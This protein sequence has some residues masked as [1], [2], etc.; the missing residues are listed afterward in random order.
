MCSKGGGTPPVPSAASTTFNSTTQPA[1]SVSPMYTDFLNRAKDL[2]NTPFNSAQ[3]GTVA[4]MNAQQTAAGN[5]MF[6]Q[7]MAMGEWGKNLGNFDA[8]RVRAI[9]SPYIQDVV[10]ATQ[11]WFNNQNAIQGN[12]LLSQAIKSGNAFGGDR[13]GIA[14]AQLSGQQQLA[15]AP[16]I[17]GLYQSGYTQALDEY[18][19]LKQFEVTGR[20]MGLQGAGAAMGWGGLQQQQAQKE[21]D[22]AQQ[23]AMM[24]SAYP[25]Q[26]LN[27]YGSI[28]GGIGPLLGQSAFGSNN[29]PEQSGLGSAL[30]VGSAAVGL[31]TA[32]AGGGGEG[33]KRGG[34]VKQRARGGLVPVLVRHNGG[35]I[36]G[37]AYGGSTD[38]DDEGSYG[39]DRSEGEARESKQRD[40]VDTPA[41]AT[42]PQDT[43]GARKVGVPN[44]YGQLR[45]PRGQAP[46]LP[47]IP[48]TGTTQPQQ[49]S[50]W[51]QG[52]NLATKAIPLATSLF[53]LSD[54]KTKTDVQ[55][56]GKTDDGEPL[57]G[58]RYKGDPK[59]YPKVVGPMA[60]PHRDDG[61]GIGGDLDGEIL[62]DADPDPVEAGQ[63]YAR[64]YSGR[65]TWFNP[66]NER[67]GY[68]YRDDSGQ[69]WTDYGAQRLR[70][71]KHASGLPSTTPGFATP[72]SADLGNWFEVS[73]PGGVK[74]Y[75]QKTDIGPA[76]VVDLNAPLAARMYG[77]PN[78]I[79]SG[80]TYVR[81]LGR[82]R[83]AGA[84]GTQWPDPSKGNTDIS[85]LPS[86][87]QGVPRAVPGA[88]LGRAP[89]AAAGPGVDGGDPRYGTGPVGTRI[90]GIP[91][92]SFAQRL[93]GN[94]FWQLGTALMAKPGIK[95]R[96]FSAIGSAAQ[97]MSA[98]QMEQRKHDI[99]ENKPE[100]MNTDQGI[101]F[102]YPD[103]SIVP[104]GL[105]GPGEGR[106]ASGEARAT[107]EAARKAEKH[108]R[109]M[110][111]DFITKKGMWGDERLGWNKDTKKYDIPLDVAA[112]TEQPAT[113]QIAPPAAPAAPAAPP[114]A[115][116]APQP[117]PQLRQ[118]EAAP[119]A[120]QP[121][122]T[123]DRRITAQPFHQ[124]AD[125][126]SIP[127]HL[128]PPAEPAQTAQAP[129][130][131]P[132]AQPQ[133]AG[134]AGQAQAG[135]TAS[136][137]P[138]TVPDEEKDTVAQLR[139]KGGFKTPLD[140]N[141]F[142][143]RMLQY[144]N[145]TPEDFDFLAARLA[146]GDTSV[147]QGYGNSKQGAVF[148]SGLRSRADQYWIDRGMSPAQANAAVAEYGGQKA[149][150]RSLGTQEARISG[151]LGT[152]MQTAPRVIE[153]SEKV[154]RT[155]YPDLNKIIQMARQKT[156]DTNVVQ[157]GL[158][159]ETFV[160]NYARA[161]GGGNSV[162]TDRAVEQAH[163][164]LNTAY[165]KG[166]INAAIDQAMVE[167][168]SE[169]Q[170]VHSAMGAY[171]GTAPAVR[172]QRGDVFRAGPGAS[173]Q[174]P[175]SGAAQPQQQKQL[176]PE[177]QKAV[178]WARRNP[179]NANAKRILELHGMQ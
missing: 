113:P 133:Q 110:E 88:Q 166:Q 85:A 109:E 69:D 141:R 47:A 84:G 129:A 4:P 65:T 148:K 111:G 3:L 15:Q 124:A 144:F 25:F 104:T 31:G 1:A 106:A 125:L 149:G 81:D 37:L 108:E 168:D 170:G 112:K 30:G 136:Q 40:Y 159:V 99:L 167:M 12:D 48:S 174:A 39:D 11:D 153:A 94:P 100:M 101:M 171:T 150:A 147:L 9:E 87:E 118:T 165:S 70:E 163:A 74:S 169:L 82:D 34:I 5:E 45:L 92:R 162:M 42:T 97:S 115:P 146:L 121:G 91:E 139:I 151:A 66:R 107:E 140:P 123:T 58:F 114:A 126:S 127:E 44:I 52:L 54:P 17:A 95:G 120:W 122:A 89:Q 177:D 60:I 86:G 128:R 50:E 10:G 152:A 138:E 76:G 21:L 131:Q 24:Q 160:N 158:A 172:Y 59:S 78:A 64:D 56:V 68:T 46:Q 72:G 6:S 26:T 79:P 98:Q 61:G 75:A 142:D 161:M 2:S 55:R 57:Y 41:E 18:N 35:I 32:L 83:P 175:Q 134:P 29:P 103:G 19:K 130:A 51:E 7:G 62:S 22:V 80:A 105:K 43:Q 13:A 28:L 143:P 157:F 173:Q 16:V 156:G 93:A 132:A 178:D 164:Y 8:S 137:S 90:P 179:G 102:R 117:A 73:G 135:P 154:D 116:A 23:N 155:K 119:P 176:A 77:R 27:W 53:A 96:E 49:K 36:A 71:G 67:G 63:Q 14:E 33:K 38:F 20:Q 145:K